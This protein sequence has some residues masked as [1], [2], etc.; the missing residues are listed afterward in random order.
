MLSDEILQ[1]YSVGKCL[2]HV[3]T[4]AFK[5]NWPG[6]ATA[7][8]ESYAP[9]VQLLSDTLQKYPKDYELH[10]FLANV[11]LV[12]DEQTKAVEMLNTALKLYKKKNGQRELP[13][14]F[15][16]K[17]STLLKRCYNEF[18]VNHGE[19]FVTL[20]QQSLYKT[21][22][23]PLGEGSFG[24][25]VGVSCQI[26]GKPVTYAVKK[27]NYGVDKI[28]PEYNIMM[29][30]DHPHILKCYG[31]FTTPL[32]AK[33]RMVLELMPYVLSSYLRNPKNDISSSQKISWSHQI[34]SG[35]HYLHS[36]QYKND[37]FLHMDLKPDNVL[38]DQE[39]KVRICD[40]GITRSGKKTGN[41]TVL[42]TQNQ[43]TVNYAAPE[44]LTGEKFSRRSD[45]FSYGVTVYAIDNRVNPPPHNDKK[46]L[47]TLMKGTGFLKGIITQCVNPER[48]KRPLTENML[49]DFE[50]EE[51]IF[52]I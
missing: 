27:F 41:E 6:L 37:V 45:I 22:N 18:R 16:V 5:D 30:L 12:K 33:A 52:P 42:L 24:K 40:F 14:S 9:L 15:P 32:T 35:L 44:I 20:T 23:Y 25:V 10:Y 29:Q 43:A 38:L 7:L 49:K 47:E 11:Y 34:L 1:N 13:D 31:K 28:L 4:T 2:A 36:T 8:D 19:S 21:S 26:E 3:Y 51:S 48:D 17:C 46:R 50:K 39:L